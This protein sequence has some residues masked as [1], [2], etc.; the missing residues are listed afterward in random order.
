MGENDK[1]F[2]DYLLIYKKMKEVG[3]LTSKCLNELSD[4]I[5]PGV[6]TIDVDHFVRNFANNYSLICA[7]DGYRGFPAAC[8]TSVN[9][10][11]CHGI[12]S[13][14]TVFDGDIIKVDVTFIKDGYYGD[15]CRTYL[16]GEKINAKIRKLLDVTEHALWKGIEVAK[17]GNT[18]GD[19]GRTI[20]RFVEANGFSVVR[21]F[22]GHGIGQDFHTPPAIPHYDAKDIPDVHRILTP[23]LTITIE[24][25]VNS[26]QKEYKILGDG[27]TVVS[28]DR[29]WSA[30]FEHTIGIT[31]T[32][33]E[34]FTI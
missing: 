2:S 9:H 28:R 11:I 23:G 3:E 12:P 7:C 22:V 1:Q 25:M 24:P 21:D 13:D 19:I 10:I 20:Q 8:C 16:V 5:K 29:S 15:S 17:P 27:W 26:G 30:Q 34:V 4:F 18:I 32:G 6:K 31:E 14:K 33:N